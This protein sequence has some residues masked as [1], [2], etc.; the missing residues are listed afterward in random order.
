MKTDQQI[1][2]G[3]RSI[4]IDALVAEEEDV[5]P[6]A[7]LTDDLG[8]ESIDYLD[9]FFHVEKMFGVRIEANEQ[10]VNSVLHDEKYVREGMI[11]DEGIEELRRRL[12]EVDL[13]PLDESRDVRRF[14]SVFTV[15]GI[16]NLVKA[17]LAAD[18]GVA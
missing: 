14:P 1:Y 4:V 18:A 8:A 6:K 15:Q 7:R 10:T 17:R 3:V 9:I 16:V 12:P 2:E 5:T 11:T 13:A